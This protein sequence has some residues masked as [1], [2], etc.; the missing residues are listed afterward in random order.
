[1]IYSI[2]DILPFLKEA[3]SYGNLFVSVGSNKNIQFLKGKTPYFSQD[4][5]VY[6]VNAIK[7]VHKAFV[8][9]GGGYAMVASEDKIEG[10]ID[11]KI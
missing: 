2:P 4:E 10:L 5:R 7:Y 6:L 3:S 11:I 8:G 9:C 1:M